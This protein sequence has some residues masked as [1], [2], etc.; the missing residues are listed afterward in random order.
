MGNSDDAAVSGAQRPMSVSVKVTMTQNC[1][2]KSLL[3]SQ[4]RSLPSQFDPIAPSNIHEIL[5][6]INS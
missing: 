1:C 5:N 3:F 2:L 4:H 6:G